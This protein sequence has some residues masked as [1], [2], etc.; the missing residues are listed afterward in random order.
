MLGRSWL[1]SLF[2]ACGCGGVASAPGEA[3]DAGADRVVVP[4]GAGLADTSEAGWT[5][6]TAPEGYAVCGGP[7]GCAQ[8]SAAC[9]TCGFA[10]GNGPP[11][12]AN[13][14]NACVNAVLGEYGPS[15]GCWNACS[16]GSICVDEFDK[17]SFSCAPYDLGVLFAKNGAGDRVRYADMGL[18]TGAALPEPSSCPG[19]TGLQVCGG[20]CGPCP[21]GQTCTGRSPLHAY[22]F[23]VPTDP[24]GPCDAD[25]GCGSGQGCF[26]FKVEASAQALANSNGMCLPASLCK[27]AATGLPGGASCAM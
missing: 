7:D 23:C 12:P 10:I 27:S 4:D 19:V 6:C 11:P 2:L 15:N 9:G 16:D 18:W 24:G 14:V 17:G 1:A 21:T 20:N 25:A 13:V 22:G 3:P 26:T 8:D 5:Q